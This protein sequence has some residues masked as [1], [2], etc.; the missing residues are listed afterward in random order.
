[1]VGLVVGP[2]DQDVAAHVL[3]AEQR[4]VGG[5]FRHRR[6]TPPG[7]ERIL[8]LQRRC[9]IRMA[10]PRT[11]TVRNAEPLHVQARL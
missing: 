5:L 7:G 3:G 4:R 8:A 1:M 6:S 9:A 10:T 2:R 11:D